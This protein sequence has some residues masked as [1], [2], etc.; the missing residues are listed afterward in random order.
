MAKKA[1]AHARFAPASLV[2]CERLAA[3]RIGG[4]WGRLP[5]PRRHVGRDAVSFERYEELRTDDGG[6]LTER[7]RPEGR[8]FKDRTA[9]CFAVEGTA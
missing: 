7:R 6:V 8:L 9:T 2:R 4:V 3:D 5:G 1:S